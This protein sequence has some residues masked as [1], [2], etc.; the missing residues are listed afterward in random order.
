MKPAAI[1]HATQRK[2]VYSHGWGAG[3]PVMWAGFIGEDA[4]LFAVA[5][6]VRDVRAVAG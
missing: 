5:A 4:R 2:F 3:D 6:T 1:E